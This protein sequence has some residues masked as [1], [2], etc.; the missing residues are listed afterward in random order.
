MEITVSFRGFIG[1]L[2]HWKMCVP[3][4]NCSQSLMSQWWCNILNKKELNKRFFFTLL[5][6]SERKTNMPYYVKKEER[7]PVSL[8]D[9]WVFYL[10]EIVSVVK[11]IFFKLMV[12]SQSAPR[13]VWTVLQIVA[14]VTAFVD[15][16]LTICHPSNF[17]KLHSTQWKGNAAHSAASFVKCLRP[18]C[19]SC[20]CSFRD[21]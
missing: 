10:N 11:F 20:V 21:Q 7:F 1:F 8:A 9:W 2:Y 12:C 5:A 3:S 4:G 16:L 6:N 15:C 14:L 17:S 13:S 18:C 19:C